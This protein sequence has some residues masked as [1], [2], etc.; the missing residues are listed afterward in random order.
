MARTNRLTSP[1]E[2][3]AGDVIDPTSTIGEFVV[4]ELEKLGGRRPRWRFW[5]TSERNPITGPHYANARFNVVRNERKDKGMSER[6]D[7]S[8][9]E[10]VRMCRKFVDGA[11]QP[12]TREWWETVIANVARKATEY[13]TADGVTYVVKY[14]AGT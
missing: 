8:P 5:W 1:Y 11:E 4:I 3:R 6:K 13:F 2:L 10:A 7:V 12:E 14:P 9:D